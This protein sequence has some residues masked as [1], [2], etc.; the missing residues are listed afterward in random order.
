VNIEADTLRGGELNS[1]LT[2]A[3][4]RIQSEH[5]HQGPA[6]AIT[7]HGENVVVVVMHDVLTKAE[8]LLAQNGKG[9]DIAE[10]RHRFQREMEDDFRDAVERLTGRKVTGFLSGNHLDPDVAAEIF[11]PDAPV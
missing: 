3:L 9:A 1:A 6:N 2:K 8:R 4:V 5:L 7:F 11:F 10:R